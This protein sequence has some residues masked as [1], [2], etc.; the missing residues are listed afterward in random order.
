MARSGLGD[1]NVVVTRMNKIG[2]KGRRDAE[3]GGDNEKRSLDRTESYRTV[4]QGT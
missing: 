2:A 3:K 1:G 4:A